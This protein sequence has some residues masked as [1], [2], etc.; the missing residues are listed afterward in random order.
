MFLLTW[1]KLDNIMKLRT[2]RDIYEKKDRLRNGDSSGTVFF[3][4]LSISYFRFIKT[5]G[6][7]PCL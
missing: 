4:C 2:N 3:L 5:K 6:E 1:K 7:Y